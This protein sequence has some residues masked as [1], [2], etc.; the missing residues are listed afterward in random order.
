MLPFDPKKPLYGF[1][2]RFPHAKRRIHVFADDRFVYFRPKNAPEDWWGTSSTSVAQFKESLLTS[3]RVSRQRQPQIIEREVLRVFFLPDPRPE[4]SRLWQIAWRPSGGYVLPVGHPRQLI[5]AYFRS[6]PRT[7]LSMLRASTADLREQFEREW[8]DPLSDVRAALDWCD[9]SYEERQW[10]SIVWQRGGRDELERVARAAC[11]MEM[12]DGWQDGQSLRL[13]IL[14]YHPSICST[15]VIIGA[16]A[17]HSGWRASS[18]HRVT[19]LFSRLQER[20]QAVVDYPAGA[21]LDKNLAWSLDYPINP[22]YGKAE[23]EIEINPLT[24]HERLESALFLRN[25]LSRHAP[26][27][28]FDWFPNAP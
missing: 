27:L 18:R 26:D 20:N 4:Q 14:V 24:Q 22:S 25:W 3:K 7:S 13:G 11:I 21:R 6:Q 5:G 15:G 19:R 9:L 8:H 16:E 1:T 12:E 28:L 17:W 23:I 10:R 2:A